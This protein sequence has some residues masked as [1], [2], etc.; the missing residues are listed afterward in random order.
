M[1]RNWIFDWSGTL[2][3]DM[4][5]VVC[6]TNHVL[7]QYGV[8]EIDRE[9]FRKSFKLPYSDFYQEYLPGVCMEEIEAHFRYGFSISEATVPKLEYSEEFLAYIKEQ[10]GR[11]FVLTSMC[12]IA[13]GE[14]LVDLGMEPY[15]ERTYAGVLDKRE[16]IGDILQEQN[17]VKEETVFVG[18][19]THDVDTAHHGG[20]WSVGVLTGYNHR[21]TLMS[22]KP[23]VLVNDLKELRG[24]LES[25]STLFT[26]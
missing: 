18:D 26:S 5:L 21:E 20:V 3:D 1:I 17:L 22:S 19:M 10:G 12:E 9:E 16:L 14:Q 4:A 13:F 8:A 25:G 11:M 2:V 23:S 15:F 24:L 6:A 7:R